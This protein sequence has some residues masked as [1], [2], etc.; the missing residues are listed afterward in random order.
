MK[1]IQ[2]CFSFVVQ[3]LIADEDEIHLTL[4]FCDDT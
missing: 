4:I 1:G 2:L 3:S